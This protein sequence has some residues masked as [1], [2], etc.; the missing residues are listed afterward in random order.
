MDGKGFKYELERYKGAKTRYTCPNCGTKRNFARYVDTDGNYLG[1]DIGRCNSEVRCGYHKPPDDNN[2]VT[3]GFVY[4]PIEPTFLRITDVFKEQCKDNLFIYLSRLYEVAD[5]ER[6]FRKYIVRSTNKKWI[7]STV[8]YQ[9]DIDGRIRTGKIIQ[10]NSETGKRVKEPYSRIYWV[11]NLITSFEF[12]L[13]QCLFGE[14]L[15]EFFDSSKGQIYLVESEKTCII[16]SLHYPNDLFIATGGLSNLSP[17][18]L[19]VL[20]GYD[21]EA[22][23]DK[24]AYDYW[25]AKL[26]PLGITVNTTLED[27]DANDGDDIA[28]LLLNN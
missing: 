22:I 6:I 16:A 8:F 7:N 9:R 15:L 21:V 3:G 12:Q 5:V 10:Y 23:P 25:K 11:H 17:K 28:D 18:K 4:K 26:E 19:S 1:D 2:V 27:S 14:H 13:E 24:G 20:N